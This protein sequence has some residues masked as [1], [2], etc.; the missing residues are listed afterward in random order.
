MTIPIGFLAL[1]LGVGIGVGVT[2]LFFYAVTQ[3]KN[4]D[5]QTSSELPRG[6]K[7][8]VES[9]DGMVFIVDRSLNV[10]VATQEAQS[11][12]LVALKK[13]QSPELAKLAEKAFTK[14][15]RSLEDVDLARPL[16]DG[17]FTVSAHATPFRKQ[18]VIVSVVD[19]GEYQ[20]VDDIR[21]EFVANVSHELKTPISSIS[22]L[23]EAI[24]ESADDPQ[25]VRKFATTLSGEASRLAEMT[26]DIIELSHLQAE[27]ALAEF[28]E[29]SVKDLVNRAVEQNAVVASSRKI[30]I[31]TGGDLDA[32]VYGD[33]DRLVIALGNLVANAVNY[34]SD[35]SQVGIGALSR[36][37]YVEIAVTDQGIGMSQE[38]TERIFERFYRTDQA[39]SRSTGGSGLGLSIVKHIISHHGGDVRVWSS[40]GKGST[41]TIR[42]P[43]AP[44]RKKMKK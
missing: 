34:S 16:G 44:S 42:I 21:R 23:A 22:L 10:K 18:F 37:S 29:V 36:G 33:T 12:A 20:R 32:Y 13:I 28:T 1:V 30:K 41:F 8:L 7:Q 3:S 9:L 25:T 39:R 11:R 35:G 15:D 38:D 17:V 26:R 6:V 31:V 4:L 5:N 27:G 14:G 2:L 40:P 19:R 43:E 24:Q